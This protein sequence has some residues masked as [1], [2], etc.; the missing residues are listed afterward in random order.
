MTNF[1][2]SWTPSNSVGVTEKIGG[3]IH[4]QGPLKP[5]VQGATRQLSTPISKLDFVAQKLDQ[6]DA[7]L[8]ARIVEA[9]QSNSRASQAQKGS[10]KH[11]DL[12]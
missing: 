6:K 1:E 2:K 12:T 8:F 3:A 9:K 7:K 5:R 4:K 10:W 11:E